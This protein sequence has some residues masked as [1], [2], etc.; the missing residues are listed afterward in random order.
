MMIA[1]FSCSR[2][3]NNSSS[4]A[5]LIFYAIRQFFHPEIIAMGPRFPVDLDK[6]VDG[7]PF[8]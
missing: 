8:F 7:P 1:P 5:S 4:V 6:V 3:D 2:N